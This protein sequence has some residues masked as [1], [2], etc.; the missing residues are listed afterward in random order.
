MI[1]NEERSLLAG[2]DILL[3][4]HFCALPHRL[5]SQTSNCRV[6]NAIRI[7]PAEQS[8]GIFVCRGYRWEYPSC[9]VAAEGV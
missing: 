4:S 1:G 8:A 3:I 9:E 5:L 7:I 6:E 2:L